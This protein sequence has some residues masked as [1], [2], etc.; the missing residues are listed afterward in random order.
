MTKSEHLTRS[1]LQINSTIPP[2]LD[3]K[4]A[5]LSIRYIEL[6]Q[7]TTYRQASRIDPDLKL[8]DDVEAL[9]GQNKQVS[10]KMSSAHL[11]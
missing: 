10:H 11:A 9:L 5:F 4:E 6:H 1:Q 7:E 8:Y 3:Q 2:Y